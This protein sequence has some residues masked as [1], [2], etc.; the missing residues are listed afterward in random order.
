M[1][2][3]IGYFVG[4]AIAVRLADRENIPRKRIVDLSFYGILTGL[5]GARIL[6]VLTN[7][8]RFN[9]SW[10]MIFAVWQG[11]GAYYGGFLL[12]LLFGFFYLRYHGISV[13]K[14]FDLGSPCVAIAHAFGRIGCFAAGCCHGD[15][16]HQ[17]W[18]FRFNTPLVTENLRGLPLHPTQLYEAI[19]L[20]SISALLL[21]FRRHQK[22]QGQVFILYL[23]AYAALRFAL[24]FFRADD[25]R[26]Y[27]FTDTVSTSQFIALSLVL[28]ATILW[29]CL[30]YGRGKTT[31]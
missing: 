9:Q 22:Y 21:L 10:Y 15:V 14:V 3:V 18:G 30:K 11:G 24:E 16:C 6:Y 31:Q 7:P 20:F 19:G 29:L 5:L 12:A 23:Y 25:D 27:I 28:T 17:P 8:D 13:L 4:L 26:G 2:V 1:F